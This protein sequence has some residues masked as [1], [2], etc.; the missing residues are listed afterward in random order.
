MLRILS[1][2]VV[3]GVLVAGSVWLAERPGAVSVD[4]LGWRIE[5]SVPVLLFALLLIAGGLTWLFSLFAG[6]ARLPGRWASRRREGRRRKGYLALTDGL[7]A[8]AG[9]DP[10]KARKLAGRAE[11]LLADPALTRFLSAQAAQLAGDADG[12]RDHFQAMLER[13]ETAALGLRGLLARALEQGDDA[14]ALDLATRARAIN[15]ADGWL[16]E[17]V[18]T[19]LIKA[20]RWR[21]ALDL[22]A[23]AV[24]RK[25]MT[26][27][28]AAHR[29]ALV[30]NEQAIR[31]ATDEDRRAAIGFARQ[32]VAADPTLTDAAVRLA[33]L[34]AEAGRPRRGAAVLEKA[35]QV[36]P[37]D[38]LAQAYGA[39]VP[40]ED[41]L[42]RVRRLEKLVA[43]RP[44]D[45]ASH[46]ALA[47]ASL[48]AKI[49]G[50]ARKHLLAAAADHPTV[51]TYRLL[52]RLEQAEYNDQAAAHKWLDQAAG[53][54]PDPA[55]S[56]REC[57]ATAA[58]WSLACPQCGRL[59]SLAWA[60]P[61]AAPAQ[62]AIAAAK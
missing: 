49:W 51:R 28:D 20:F 31:A 36:Q 62:L 35:W 52:A 61:R 3:V 43:G 18:F 10:T 15:P 57:A 54:P 50:Q 19:L 29:K 42:Q 17:T 47:E 25:A 38:P 7:A 58:R 27:A 56:C 30:L 33:G 14:A 9:G 45:R 4:W 2:V 24:R 26:P 41:P 21:E 44:D 60:P 53:A 6:L 59:D 12:A 5:T 46:L 13:P 55:W 22:L 37:A 48:E 34:Y 1:F 23:D 32:A 11:K 8:A 40:G 39:L 16:A